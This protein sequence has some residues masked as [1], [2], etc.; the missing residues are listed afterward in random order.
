MQESIGETEKDKRT[1][2]GTVTDESTGKHDSIHGD[3]VNM[4]EGE[5]A[6]SDTG[7][8][9]EEATTDKSLPVGNFKNNKYEKS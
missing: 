4:D 3:T 5:P 9:Q 1:E 2:T 7:T 8:T 6:G